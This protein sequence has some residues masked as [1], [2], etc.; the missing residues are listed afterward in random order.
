M[1]RQL[2]LAALCL[3]MCGACAGL[4]FIVGPCTVLSPALF[5]FVGAFYGAGMTVAMKHPAEKGKNEQG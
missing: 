1:K 2:I 3:V 4:A 5:I